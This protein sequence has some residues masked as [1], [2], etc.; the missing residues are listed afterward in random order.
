RVAESAAWHLEDCINDYGIATLAEALG[1]PLYAS[2]FRQRSLAY[3]NLFSPSLGFFRGKRLDGDFRTPDSAFRPNEW[4]NEFSE[5]SAW[6]YVAAANHDPRGMAEL[7]GGL[8]PFAN[9]LDAVLHASRDFAHGSYESVLHEMREAYD[10]NMGQYAHSNEPV[11]HML[12]MFD[13]A[14]QPWK[15]QRY[16][17][18]VSTRLYG[19]GLADGRG[20][21]GDEDNGQ[22]SAWYVWSALGFYPASPGHAEYAIGSPLHDRMALHLENGRTFAV[23]A[24]NQRADHPYIQ[25][26]TLDGAPYNKVYLSH[27]TIL[28]GGVLELV[29]GAAPSAWGAAPEARP[30]SITLD[31][32]PPVALA[33]CARDGR[34]IA[35]GEN[36]AGHEGGEQAFDDDS[37]TK[38]LTFASSGS[39]EY[40]LRK[41]CVMQMYTLTSADDAPARDPSDW[42]LEGSHDGSTWI[43]LDAK[44]GESFRWRHQ[45][46]V[47]GTRNRDGYEYYRLRITKN[48]SDAATQLAEVELLRA[49]DD[50]DEY[51]HG[52]MPGRSGCSA[53]PRANSP[54]WFYGIPWMIWLR[55]RTRRAL[56]LKRRSVAGRNPP[57]TTST[58][59]RCDTTATNEAA[60]STARLTTR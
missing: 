31:S 13:Y 7:Y 18:E 48:H 49:A 16:V 56:H 36:A 39:L 47:F 23:V 5:G 6:Q 12:Y 58:H 55:R 42:T 54:T 26:A 35:S 59:T 11:Q 2:Y 53:S 34:V 9:K 44:H 40:A 17:R 24:R 43:L 29:M 45:T 51:G 19:S 21:L 30:S 52:T 25:K 15:T 46:R 37:N 27:E 8:E 3:A 28:R 32:H 4:G 50:S 57:T 14:G 41:P 20:Y 1:D 33:D 60:R 10:A 22:M 38:W